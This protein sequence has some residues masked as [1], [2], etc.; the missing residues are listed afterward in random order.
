[1]KDSSTK[2]KII[3]RSMLG[4]PLGLAISYFNALAISIV[5]GNGIFYP[6]VPALIQ[7]CGSELNAVLLQAACSCLYGAVW[8]GASVIWEIERWSLLRMTL[9]HLIVCSLATFPIAYITYWMSHH[10]GGILKYFAIFFTIY[11]GIWLL[12]FFKTKRQIRQINDKMQKQSTIEK[13]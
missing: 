8:G 11:L 9:T 7:D 13:S 1:M 3:L 10:I 5:V 6:V 12:L 2:R 4:A